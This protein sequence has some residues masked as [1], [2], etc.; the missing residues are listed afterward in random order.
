MPKS[1][2]ICTKQAKFFFEALRLDGNFDASSGWLTRFKQRHGIRE[3]SI[4]GEK[5]TGD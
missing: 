2:L 4:Q 3:M 5:L 1:G